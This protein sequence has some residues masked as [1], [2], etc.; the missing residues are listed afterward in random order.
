[1]ICKY[2]PEKLFNYTAV[3]ARSHNGTTSEVGKTDCWITKGDIREGQHR[4]MIIIAKS[5]YTHKSPEPM[6]EET[7]T[8][9]TETENTVFKKNVSD[10]RTNT[11][12]CIAGVSHAE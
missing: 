3:L 7:N 10:A 2:R 8:K 5:I 4:L 6:L 12:K 11:K 9:K 1:M